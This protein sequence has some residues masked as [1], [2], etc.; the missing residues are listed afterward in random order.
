[1]DKM[2]NIF[3]NEKIMNGIKKVWTIC[4]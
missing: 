4:M 2:D 1:M 3:L